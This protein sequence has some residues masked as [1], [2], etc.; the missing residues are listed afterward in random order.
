MSTALQ[1]LI[2]LEKDARD[3]GFDWPDQ[4]MIIEQAISECEEISEAIAKGE[5]K[6]RI[7]E[8]IG[9]LLHTAIS[10]CLFSGFEPEQTLANV[11]DKFSSRLLALKEITK[12]QGLSTLKGQSIQF[13][14][15]LWLEAKS[16]AQTTAKR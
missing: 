8:E 16:S 4:Q 7:Q 14:M 6:E 13:M 1:T 12:K 9:D 15:E 11:V 5:G 3:F 10:L 2:S